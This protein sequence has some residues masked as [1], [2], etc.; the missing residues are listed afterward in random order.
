MEVVGQLG[1]RFGTFA[2]SIRF[3]LYVRIGLSI[4]TTLT[5]SVSVSTM[6]G[7]RK[8][9]DP[10][11]GVSDLFSGDARQVA[12]S[13]GFTCEHTDW[14]SSGANIT[15]YCTQHYRD[16]MYS[17]IYLRASANSVK[18]ATFSLR[19]HTLALGDLVVLWGQPITRPICETLV[20]SWSTHQM[21]AMVVVA[22]TTPI[23]YA[24]PIPFISFLHEGW[25]VW[26][27]AL[28]NDALHGC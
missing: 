11:S 4:L 8:M 7:R 25:P 18:E 20:V 5:I 17:D 23:N 12:M 26:G 10:F 24:A 14:P 13:G 28:A 3:P 6:A 1:R 27:R 22:R 21:T 19:A 15:N 2:T 9:S 16:Q